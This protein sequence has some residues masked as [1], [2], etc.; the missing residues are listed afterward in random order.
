MGK[1]RYR[2]CNAD[3][4]FAEGAIDA[5]TIEDAQDALW[6]QG[7]TPYQVRP[8]SEDHAKW[9]QREIS[10]GAKSKTADLTAFT[11]ELATLTAAD[12]PLDDSL[13]ILRDQVSSGRLR[14]LVGHLRDGILNGMLLSDAM[15]AQPAIFPAD[16]IAAVRAG[17][18]G[19]TI[20]QV[21]TE[22]AHL[23]EQRLAIENRIKSALIYPSILSVLSFITLAIIAG[24]LIPNIAP[25][26]AESGKPAPFIIQFMLALHERW[27]EIVVFLTLIALV[28][29]AGVS[30]ARRKTSS[31]LWLDRYKT[32]IPILGPFLLQQDAAR[33][34]RTVG[35]MLKAGI[36]LL[37]AV[38]SGR[39]VIRNQ[40]VAA[41]V[42]RAIQF[43]QQGIALHQALRK[44]SAFPPMTLQMIAVGE[45][46]G[47][48]ERMITRVAITLE[49]QMQ[50]SIE[51]FMAA[52]TPMLTVGIAAMIGA[53]ILP[54][55]SA[56]LSINDLAAK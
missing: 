24:G 21:F 11:R 5:V 56:V 1:F 36:P 19:G 3:G 41:G 47:K 12:I 13:R 44:E 50:T 43:V 18:L 45:E 48:L 28:L 26:F 40:H 34:S 10:F 46:S 17:E 8:Y 55:M 25:I 16:Y 51:R 4:T 7:L 35:T 38:T 20:N 2:A 22:L 49:Q 9:W 54:I 32:K 33:F 15:A 14:T 30:T 31:R 23:L 37:Q 42:D 29:V 39:A 53:F 52:L 6:C 27:P